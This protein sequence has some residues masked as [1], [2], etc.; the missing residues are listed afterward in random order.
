[1]FHKEQTDVNAIRKWKKT[2]Y[3]MSSDQFAKQLSY[4]L[5]ETDI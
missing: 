1:M 5:L 3:L 4:K 2:T